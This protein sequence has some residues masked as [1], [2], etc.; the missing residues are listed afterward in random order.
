LAHCRKSFFDENKLSTCF[1]ALRFYHEVKAN[2]WEL[3]DKGG[4]GL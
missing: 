2:A 1:S 3:G 4:L